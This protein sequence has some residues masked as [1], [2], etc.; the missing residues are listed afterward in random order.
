MDTGMLWFDNN[1]KRDLDTKID[2]AAK[3]F[4]D[5]YGRKP[6]LCYVHPSMIDGKPSRN[7]NGKAF[8]TGDIELRTMSQI[9]PNH[10]W[11]TYNGKDVSQVS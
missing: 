1:A 11:I 5:K 7:G 8:S 9:L 4:Q 3:Y 2:R 6:T 10:F